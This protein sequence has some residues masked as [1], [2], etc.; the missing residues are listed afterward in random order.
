MHM[1]M[2]AEGIT[3]N[4]LCDDDVIC[5]LKLMEML[6][7]FWFFDIVSCSTEILGDMARRRAWCE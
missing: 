4:M 2:Q 3:S 5:V 7:C 6:C 1:N